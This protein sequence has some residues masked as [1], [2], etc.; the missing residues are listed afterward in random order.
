MNKGGAED[1]AAYNKTAYSLIK[2]DNYNLNGKPYFDSLRKTFLGIEQRVDSQYGTPKSIMAECW[3]K[4]KINWAML[5]WRGRGG[6]N[7]LNLREL[8]RNES[9][10]M[11]LIR[12]S[13]NPRFT[14][15]PTT[16]GK[17]DV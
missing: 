2:C 4:N 15:F 1:A 5:P 13:L 17:R 14:A 6:G 3:R 10:Q 7:Y 16:D 8:R 12:N 11:K 9:E